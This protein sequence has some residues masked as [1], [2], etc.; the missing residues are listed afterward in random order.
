MRPLIRNIEGEPRP[1]IMDARAARMRMLDT[2]IR[3]CFYKLLRRPYRRPAYRTAKRTPEQDMRTKL[4]IE[5][6]LGR[7]SPDPETVRYF[8]ERARLLQLTDTDTTEEAKRLLVAE[9][10]RC[11]PEDEAYVLGLPRHPRGDLRS[12]TEAMAALARVEEAAAAETERLSP[13]SAAAAQ[14]G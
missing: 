14:T 7:H 8:Q 10:P 3:R 11:S 2:R 5:S 12:N 6:F 4:A 13:L 9:G 1:L